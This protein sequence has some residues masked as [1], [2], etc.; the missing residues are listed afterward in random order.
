VRR[1]AIATKGAVTAE[2]LAG[3][4]AEI[5]HAAIEHCG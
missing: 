1:H 4:L 2:V 3:I 5:R